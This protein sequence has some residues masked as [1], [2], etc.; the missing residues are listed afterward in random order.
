MYNSATGERLPVTEGESWL[1]HTALKLTSV[2]I[3]TP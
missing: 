2:T 3:R 1:N